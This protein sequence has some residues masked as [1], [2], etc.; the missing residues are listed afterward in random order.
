MKARYVK[1][2]KLRSNFYLVE[3]PELHL[4]T[5]LKTYYKHGFND[6]NQHL[7]N[8]VDDEDYMDEEYVNELRN[9]KHTYD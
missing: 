4:R 1:S 6:K 3:N 2:H 7:R 5:H 8:R 9:L